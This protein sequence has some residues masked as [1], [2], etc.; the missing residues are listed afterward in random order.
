MDSRPCS[1]Q[2]ETFERTSRNGV[3]SVFEFFTTRIRPVCS[4]TNRRVL[5][6]GGAVTYT[7]WS[8]LPTRDSPT[9]LPAG[10]ALAGVSVELVAGAAGVAVVP[11]ASSPPSPA[12]QATRTTRPSRQRARE[13]RLIFFRMAY[14]LLR[15]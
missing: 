4:T 14:V 1:S 2:H 15:P 13:R 5:S 12:P 3:E 6:P 8:K 9:P 10:R 7:G 11:D